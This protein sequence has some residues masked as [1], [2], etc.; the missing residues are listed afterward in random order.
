VTKPY[1]GDVA[2]LAWPQ[3][4]AELERLRLLRVPRLLL[5]PAEGD[6]P[7]D[8]DPLV[9]WVR[10]PASAQDIAARVIG[11]LRR[12]TDDDD[13]TEDVPGVDAHGRLVF[14]TRWAALSPTEARLAR[15]LCDRYREVVSEPELLRHGWEEGAPP[16]PNALRV[17][18]TRLRHRIA[19]LGIE[20]VS[21]RNQGVILQPRREALE[22]GVT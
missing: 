8:S 12:A 19:G 2:V 14:G 9:D 1:R 4:A 6:P 20:V 10:M 18:L 7:S 5:V 15:V 21:V 22:V 3:Q 11:L 16:R 13:A 17:H